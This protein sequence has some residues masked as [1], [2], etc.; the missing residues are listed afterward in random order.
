MALIYKT[1]EF[2]EFNWK[3]FIGLFSFELW[4]MI[5]LSFTLCSI[6]WEYLCFRLESN[7]PFD[8]S[9][10]MIACIAALVGQGNFRDTEKYSTRIILMTMLAGSLVLNAAYS[11]N[12]TSVLFNKKVSKPFDSVHSLYYKT[13]YTIGTIGSTSHSARFEV[14]FF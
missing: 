13:D 10:T 5:G 6:I 4:F 3:T 11:A 2:S 14:Y 12:L 9:M 7:K 8:P 1:P